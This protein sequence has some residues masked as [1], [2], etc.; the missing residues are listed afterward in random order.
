MNSKSLISAFVLLLTISSISFAEPPGRVGEDDRGSGPGS[1]RPGPAIGHEGGN[2]GPSRPGPGFNPGNGPR[3]I[4]RPISR[5][6]P[7]PRP[8]PRPNFPP[9]FPPAFNEPYIPTPQVHIEQIY[10]GRSVENE[11]ISLTQLSALNRRYSGWTIRSVRAQ[12]TPNSSARTTVRL[13]VDERVVGMQINP[14]N[15]INI[16]PNQGIS[17]GG[18]RIE[19]WINGSTFIHSIEIEVQQ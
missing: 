9:F 12:T 1:G 7:M 17:I 4:P 2:R 11:R 18:A 15:Q 13:A 14:G 8:L 10:I 3:P 6:R 19:L 16:F 5:P